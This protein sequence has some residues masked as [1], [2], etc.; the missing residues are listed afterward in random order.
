MKANAVVLAAILAVI[1]VPNTMA[2]RPKAAPL[3]VEGEFPSLDGAPHP[4]SALGPRNTKV[5]GWWLSASIR[6]SSNSRRTF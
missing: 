1:V 5:R 3:R 2:A 6:P 4:M